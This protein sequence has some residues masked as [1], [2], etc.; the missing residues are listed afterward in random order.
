[1]LYL[2][3]YPYLDAILTRFEVLKENE[4]AASRFLPFAVE[5]TWIMSR[6]DKL[7]GY[8]DLCAKQELKSSTLG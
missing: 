5:A 3:A 8:L 7:E 4:S 1:M 6:W 2:L